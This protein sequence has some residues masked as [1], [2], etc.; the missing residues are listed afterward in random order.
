MTRLIFDQKERVGTWVR[1]QTGLG[2]RWCDYY[3]L[4]LELNGNL[5]SGLVFNNYNGSSISAHIA[6]THTTKLLPK[7]LDH[8][9][10]HYAFGQCGV[11]RITGQIDSGNERSLRLAYHV[12]FEFE[13]R[14]RCAGHNGQDLVLLVLWPNNYYR[15]GKLNEPS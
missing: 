7:L 1:E 10:V 9:L 14:L 2:G 13:A 3:A 6:V 4:G 12:G 15:R 5:V 11:K 8:G